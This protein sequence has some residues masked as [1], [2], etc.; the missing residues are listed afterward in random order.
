MENKKDPEST[1]FEIDTMRKKVVIIGH[2]YTSRLAVIRSVAQMGCEVTV[3]VMAGNKKHSEK[4]DTKKPIDCYSKYVDRFLFCYFRDEEGLIRL[5]LSQCVDSKQKVV[6]F[7]DN[8]FAS[9]VIDRHQDELKEHFYFPHIHH[10]T[11]AVVEW[12]NKEKQKEL[13]RSM[14]LTVSMSHTVSIMDSQYQLPDGINYPCFIKPLASIVGGK[15][16]LRRC[17]TEDELRGVLDYAVDMFG[18]IDVLVEDF[19]EIE[20]E[21]AVVGFSDG[22]EVV[23]PGVI[24]IQT[25]TH[26]GHFG[27]ACIGKVSPIDGF[28][29]LIAQFKQ[30]VLQ[31]GYTGVFDIDFWMDKGQYY[32]G[33][34][35]LRIGGSAYA[36]YKLGVN[37]PAMFVKSVSGDSIADMQK[38]VESESTF[39]NERMCLDDW[40]TGYMK[41][42]E[43]HRLLN[44]TDISF[45]RDVEDN[46]PWRAYKAEYVIRKIK[47]IVKSMIGR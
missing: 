32:F 47:R 11:G 8:D 26:G 12:M 46:A 42:E 29:D 35:N 25:M 38:V 23:I 7:P 43:Y 24:E 20:K 5:L 18:S 30:L 21:Y 31:V 28:E 16:I 34:L 37:L 36:I 1:P 41:T 19:T 27:V 22:K 13:A 14:G 40:Y 17:D 4:L 44:S 10:T 45:I 3:V 9:A 15:R 2:G 6:I 33:E 39:I